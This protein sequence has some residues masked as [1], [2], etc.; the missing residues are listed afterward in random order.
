M[1]LLFFLLPF[2]LF[3]PLQASPPIAKLAKSTARV[4]LQVQAVIATLTQRIVPPE[5]V[6]TSS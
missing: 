3:T 6:I 1:L 5:R 4:Q 2:L